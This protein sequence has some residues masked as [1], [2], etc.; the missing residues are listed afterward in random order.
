VKDDKPQVKY[1][2]RATA[3][4]KDIWEYSARM[5]SATQANKYTDKIEATCRI[6]ARN[7]RLG[8]RYEGLPTP[9]LRYRVGRHVIFFTV[10]PDG[11]E[12]VRI[13]HDSMDFASR[14]GEN[15]Q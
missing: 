12:I 10:L 2:I 7:T 4:L 3:E 6:L 9:L 13:L 5:W 11:I 1:S 14:I 15:I 8:R